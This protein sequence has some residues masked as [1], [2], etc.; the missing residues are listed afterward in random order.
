MKLIIIIKLFI[1]LIILFYYINYEM[2][3]NILN[4]LFYGLLFI[5]NKFFKI[6]TSTKIDNRTSLCIVENKKFYILNND[7]IVSG[8]LSVGVPWEK[9]MQKYFIKYRD[10]N[11]NALD[12]GANIGAHTVYLAENFKKVYAFEPQIEVYKLLN[13]NI[14]LNNINNVITYN[15]GLGNE[16]T[17]VNMREFNVDEQE[18][19]GAINIEK[20]GTGEE[21]MVKTLDSYNFINIKF[22]K[23][24]V[25]GYEYFVLLGGKNTF[26]QSKPV[27]IIELNHCG[28]EYRQDVNNFFKDINYKLKRISHDDYL[29]EPN[30]C[31]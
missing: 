28:A 27:I 26:L 8:Y 22:I 17:K 2:C 1:F 31:H 15:Y 25:E 24:D 5:L 30:E 19:I 14:K 13:K 23:M 3:N 4:I 16:E 9:F 6:S 10:M 12:I 11:M 7:F 18:N 21:I 29:A 20:G